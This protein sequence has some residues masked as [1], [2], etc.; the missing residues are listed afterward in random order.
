M[1]SVFT[2][3]AY[4]NDPLHFIEYYSYRFYFPFRPFFEIY[5]QSISASI[6][7]KMS[8]EKVMKNSN[9]AE[10]SKKEMTVK[11]YYEDEIRCFETNFDEI[12][13][14]PLLRKVHQ[15]F[16]KLNINLI[17]LFWRGNFEAFSIKN[18]A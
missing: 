9:S 18:F 6:T 4:F 8:F 15:F 2:D 1:I 7:L 16:P 5:T 14:L 12:S 3:L 17:K 13:Y 11:L 10:N